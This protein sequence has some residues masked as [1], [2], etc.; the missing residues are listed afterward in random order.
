AAPPIE[1]VVL[2]MAPPTWPVRPPPPPMSCAEAGAI[3]SIA[4]R[5][6]EAIKSFVFI[7]VS[8]SCAGLKCRLRGENERPSRFLPKNLRAMK[9]GRNHK[10]HHVRALPDHARD[11]AS[12]R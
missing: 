7:M 2:P 10:Y 11:C 8:S 1:P 4:A 3:V 12:Q 6:V 9:S 5:A